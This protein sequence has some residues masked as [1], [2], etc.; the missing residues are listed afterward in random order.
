MKIRIIKNN[1]PYDTWGLPCSDISNYI[2]QEFE[3]INI[4]GEII[5]I[6]T[7][8]KGVLDIYSGEYEIV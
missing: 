8:D 1:P 6:N 5:A 3:A 7:Q 2:G 4:D